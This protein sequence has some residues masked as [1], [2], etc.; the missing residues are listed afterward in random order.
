[1]NE[2]TTTTLV[3]PAFDHII[4]RPRLISILEEAD[5]RVVVLAAPA[6]YGKT[7]LARQWSAR[8]TGPVVWHRTTRASGDVT[9]LAVRLDEA[10]AKAV[11]DVSRDPN[12]IPTIASVNGNPGPL[13]R[14]LISIYGSL[15]REVLVVMDEWETAGT[16]EAEELLSML[17]EGLNVRFLITARTRPAWFSPRLEVY[18]EG[19]ELGMGELTMTDAEAI[20][21]LSV[22]ESPED[23]EALL[24]NA[25]GWPAVLGLAAR[26]EA[27]TLPRDS[28]P[29][30]ELFEYFARELLDRARDETRHAL[31]LIAAAGVSDAATAELL[32][33]DQTRAALDDAVRLGLLRVEADATMDLHPL[34]KEL[35]LR[36]LTGLCA[37]KREGLVRE[38]EPLLNTQRWDESLTAAETVSDRSFISRSLHEALPTL[39]NPVRVATLRRWVAAG[40]GVDDQSGSTDLADA[41]LALREGAF[42]RAMARGKLAAELLDGDL[43]ATA[44]LAVA[45]AA[46]L[47]DHPRALRHHLGQA[48]ELAQSG[49]TQSAALWAAFIETFDDER[50]GA[51]KR[52]RE[53][54]AKTGPSGD[55]LLRLAHGSILLALLKGQL[56]AALEDAKPALSLL[57]T[58]ADPMVR[59]AFLNIY[60]GGSGIAAH[61]NTALRSA[62]LELSLAAEYELDFVHRYALLNKARAAIGLRQ[63]RIGERSLAQLERQLPEQVEPFVEVSRSM[64]R[65]RLYITIGDLERA[66]DILSLDLG[67]RVTRAAGGEYLALRALVL[68]A[69]GDTRGATIAAAL[70]TRTSRT[71]AVRSLCSAAEL[72]S[73]PADL[74][75]CPRDFLE[76][77]GRLGAWDT[78]V[79]AS[80]ASIDFAHALAEDEPSRSRLRLLLLESNDSTIARRVGLKVPRAARRVT[81]LSPREQEIHELIA[82]GMTN[83]EIS[84]LLF[85]SESTTKVHVRH[86]LEKLGVRSRVEATRVWRATEADVD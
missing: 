29:P 43:S 18:G 70:A 38:L 20:V 8:Q 76:L 66:H 69:Q 67:P 10:L 79:I 26:R 46:M 58:D 3:Q 86:I 84:R 21:V 55:Q 85:I 62:D 56:E 45:R 60:S 14:A 1:M 23:A 27:S 36:R 12:R 24:T 40:R 30:A 33:G 74:G 7:T 37:R 13:G 15:G 78:A 2:G 28:G 68:A 80:R 64:E 73:A 6:G 41:E 77:V 35:L 31:T 63:L 48:T 39:L 81:K 11:P 25:R 53:F 65:A 49:R 57:D 44:H 42:D 4:E 5:A 47:A 83:P 50:P 19:L 61:Y 22:E 59:T 75:R 34:L 54:Q 32:L 9:V 72:M 71:S 17:V 16:E 51:A 82:Q 52:L